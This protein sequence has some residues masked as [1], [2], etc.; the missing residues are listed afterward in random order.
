MP[1]PHPLVKTLFNLRGNPRACVYTEPLWGIPYNLFSPYASL[2]MYALG[3]TDRQIGLIASIG[4]AF[5]I[6]FSLLGG[7]ITDK[8]GRRY[9]TFI[10]D[11]LCWSLPC[12]IWAL[13]QNFIYFVIAAV[14]N[15][16]FRVTSNSWNCLLV[17]DSDKNQIVSIYT[18]IYIFAQCTAFIA[19]IAGLFVGAYGL[20]PTVRVFYFISFI[21]MSIKFICTF[22]FSTE[23]SHGIV[24]MKETKHL[25]LLKMFSGY[26]DVVRQ[27]LKTRE[28]MTTL[29]LMLI[30]S[31]T[32]MVNS[33]F[34]PIMVTENLNISNKAIGIFPFVRS[35]VMLLF[36]FTIVPRINV[37]TYKK[38]MLFGFCIFVVSQLLLILTPSKGYLM[39]IVSI[40]LEASSLSLINPLVDSLQVIMVDPQ[41][42]PRIIAILYVIVISITSPF[43]WISGTLSSLDRRLP[44]IM[45]LLLLS[46]GF[47]LTYY[48]S[49]SSVEKNIVE[50]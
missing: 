1:K 5:Q 14:F 13:S 26:G 2:Y 27:I 50:A 18:W 32:S 4:M 8:L 12:M 15:S 42:R 34:W 9:T 3:V 43:G 33:T 28:T 11:F 45:N 22:A 30:V 46:F 41:E 38:P 29:G 19:P 21:M 17:E 31:V 40:L 6:L 35:S 47:L 16:I 7:I 25:S 39:L 10:F 23:T 36:F 44:F 20:I 48:S 37:S 24:R 49:V